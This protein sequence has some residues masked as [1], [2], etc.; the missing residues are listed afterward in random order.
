MEYLELVKKRFG[1][2]DLEKVLNSTV[3]KAKN[4][5]KNRYD[6]YLIN[7]IETTLELQGGFKAYDY[8]FDYEYNRL[9]LSKY[10]NIKNRLFELAKSPLYS[11]YITYHE[12]NEFLEKICAFIYYDK[13][14]ENFDEIITAL[15]NNLSEIDY[16]LR[17]INLP[18]I[19]KKFTEEENIKRN[20]VECDFFEHAYIITLEAKI[21]NLENDY[22][23]END[24]FMKYKFNLNV[25]SVGTLYNLL[26]KFNL[27][28]DKMN[29]GKFCHSLY[30]DDSQII[31]LC[32]INSK[33]KVPE[34]GYLLQLIQNHFWLRN[35]EDFLSTLAKTFKVE[36]SH[37][38]FMDFSIKGA[39]PIIRLNEK[40]D[41][42]PSEN[43]HFIKSNIDRMIKLQ[44]FSK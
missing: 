34:F 10:I 27:F 8:Q 1:V 32:L 18:K 15:K 42:E 2:N 25:V 33:L 16:C 12:T 30:P 24:L 43:R 38:N 11:I 19:Q 41:E 3:N 13:G 36:T 21:N 7:F 9:A 37:E 29:F 6:A 39:K 28:V 26:Q 17:V 31:K 35:R 23:R 20:I 14:K 40:L 5:A 22:L 44:K 4:Q